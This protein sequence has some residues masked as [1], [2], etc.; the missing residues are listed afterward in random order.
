M[1]LCREVDPFSLFSPLCLYK[2][3]KDHPQLFDRLADLLENQIFVNV[4]V[5]H[6]GSEVFQIMRDVSDSSTLLFGDIGISFL[7]V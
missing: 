3:S 5:F 2:M 1:L 4:P 6:H 7:H